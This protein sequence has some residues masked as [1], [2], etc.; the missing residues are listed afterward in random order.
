MPMSKVD[1]EQVSQTPSIRKRIER[2]CQRIKQTDKYT[3]GQEE[4]AC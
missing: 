2:V 4:G 1:M 3:R